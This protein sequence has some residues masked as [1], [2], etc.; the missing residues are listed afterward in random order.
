MTR[1]LFHFNMSED[2]LP[3]SNKDDA[4]FMLFYKFYQ[5]VNTVLD[6]ILGKDVSGNTERDAVLKAL[7]AGTKSTAEFCKLPEIIKCFEEFTKK[8][9]SLKADALTLSGPIDSKFPFIAEIY[10]SLVANNYF[11]AS[12]AVVSSTDD[13]SPYKLVDLTDAK[14]IK[15]D[16]DDRPVIVD[17]FKS[18][19]THKLVEGR[20]ASAG[21]ILKINCDAI[22]T[23]VFTGGGKRK[24]RTASKKASS[25]KASQKGGAKRKSKK[26]SSKKGSKK[27]SKKASQKGGAKRRSKKAG[28][29]KAG[30]KKAGSKKAGSKKA[31]SK[32]TSMKG[33]AKRRSKKAGSKKAA[34]KKKASSKKVSSKKTS[35]KGG[36]RR[37]RAG[38]KKVA[39]K[40]VASKKTASK[41]TSS[42]RKA[43]KKASMK[44]GKRR[45]RAGSKKGSKKVASKKRASKKGSK[46]RTRK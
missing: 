43:S 35:M 22:N 38:S 15:F 3:Q 10:N 44:G 21:T 46:S 2:K 11:I 34:S 28:S 30:S 41:K 26:A 18:L 42:K 14:V 27:A 32:K 24:K 12:K 40:K 4:V 9:A 33:G 20:N 39:S 16:S 1:C 29:K 25:K 17:S 31:G 13:C 5:T 19:L 45:S 37:S 8:Q 36:K 23:D 7:K 6:E